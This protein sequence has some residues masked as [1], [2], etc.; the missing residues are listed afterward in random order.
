M[1]PRPGHHL[2]LFLV[3]HGGLPAD[4]ALDRALAPLDDPGAAAAIV[5]GGFR[6][7]RVDRPR[8]RTLYANRQG[9]FRVSC[10]ACGN[11]L[12]P[13]FGAALTAWREGGASSV[14]CS[15]CGAISSLEALDFAPQAAFGDGAVVLVDARSFG[16]TASG[17]ATFRDLLGPFELVGSR[18]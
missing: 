9:G 11:N 2:D 13:D 10:P 8:R 4:D 12:A 6:G 1:P 17:Q 3:P 16:L 7:V 5:D 14:G 15:A 18:R